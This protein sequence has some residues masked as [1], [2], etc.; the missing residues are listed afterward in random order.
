[1]T[2]EL[3]ELLA[4][5]LQKFLDG[6]DAT[7]AFMH[8]Q[9][10]DVIQQVLNWYFV[11]YSVTALFAVVLFS[12]QV[13]LSYYWIAK[14]EPT[15]DSSFKGFGIVFGVGGLGLFFIIT[16]VTLFNLQWLK[17]WI[18]PKLWLIEYTASLAK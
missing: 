16:E 5:T 2:E 6:V 4:Q 1:M 17:I 3:D 11:Y 10:P 8:E 13:Y 9:L 14:V 12:L 15:L 7:T 18:A